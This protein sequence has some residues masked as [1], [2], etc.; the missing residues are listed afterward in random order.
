MF[1]LE[2]DIIAKQGFFESMKKYIEQVLSE[3]WLFLEFSQ[4]GFIGQCLV[5]SIHSLMPCLFLTSS[6][7]LFLF[8]SCFICLLMLFVHLDQFFVVS[9][10]VVNAN[11]WSLFLQ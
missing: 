9:R 11:E 5:L 10:A 2:D 4:L 8:I 1:Q 6:L 3:E 7:S